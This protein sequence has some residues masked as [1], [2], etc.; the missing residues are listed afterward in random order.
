MW[1]RFDIRVRLPCAL[2]GRVHREAESSHFR[3]EGRAFQAESLGGTV[4]AADD[5]VG[6]SKRGND[7]G[8]ICVC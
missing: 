3:N 8:L 5:P 4:S 6:L 1:R 2:I 7:V